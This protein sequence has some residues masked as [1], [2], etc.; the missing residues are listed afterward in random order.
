MATKSEMGPSRRP[1]VFLDRDGTINV[2]KDYLHRVEDFEFIPGA[3]EAIRSLN[4]AG[5]LVV[6]VTNQSGVARGLY[7]EE[8]V[9]RLH[10][11]LRRVLQTFG[12]AVDAFYYCPHHPEHGT[13]D[14]AVPC[15]CRKP[16]PGMLRQ[17]AEDLCIDLKK[18]W[19]IGD[20]LADVEAGQAVGCRAILVETGYGRS[21]REKLRD[22]RAMVC[23]D[24][25]AA[26]EFLCHAP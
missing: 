14:Y 2:E 15:T 24:I 10:D 9:V 26:V 20:K 23:G 18:S 6:V 16:E 3:P 5:F 17:A 7:S 12:A 1:A 25:R 22:D 8:D 19:I 4:D 13:G 21:E 11:H